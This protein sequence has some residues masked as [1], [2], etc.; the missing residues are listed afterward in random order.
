MK[1]IICLLLFISAGFT[2]FSQEILIP[3]GY[4]YNQSHN[5]HLGVDVQ[6]TKETFFI[7]GISSNTTFINSKLKLDPEIHASIIPF[8]SENSNLFL[9]YFMTEIAA[10]KKFLNP[11]LGLSV[12][13]VIKL[14]MG[15]A[16]PYNTH[17]KDYK[18]LTFGLIFSLGSMKSA[19]MM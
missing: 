10:T 19:K 13:N 2:S 9:S 8:S 16:I 17:N 4:V 15:Y 5:F 7:V 18:G 3:V 11:S 6:L 1:K 12:F 14:K